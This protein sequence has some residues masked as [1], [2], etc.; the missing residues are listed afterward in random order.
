MTD[1]Q[2]HLNNTNDDGCKDS[3]LQ[4]LKATDVLTT[5]WKQ[6][7]GLKEHEITFPPSYKYN[8]G[9][10]K[11]E[12]K[13]YFGA[14]GRLPGYADRI[15]VSEH[16]VAPDRPQPYALVD[17]EPT[18]DHFP[19]MSKWKL[20]GCSWTIVSYNASHKEDERFVEYLKRLEDDIIILTLQELNPSV[21]RFYTTHLNDWGT[22][23]GCGIG[24]DHWLAGIANLWGERFMQAIFVRGKIGGLE[25]VK[26]TRSNFKKNTKGILFA[27]ATSGVG[28]RIHIASVH[29]P[30]RTLGKF[31]EFMTQLKDTIPE[32]ERVVVAGDFNS[33]SMIGCYKYEKNVDSTMHVDCKKSPFEVLLQQQS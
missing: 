24:D 14:E 4:H 32:K 11:L 6:A 21:L 16:F 9:N 26:C 27:S 13:S 15:L 31:N 10:M 25:K 12:K 8:D 22:V 19:V 17:I 3:V 20:D 1:V 5:A 28:V 30:F 29:G 33:R 7:L 2:T 23:N 18:S